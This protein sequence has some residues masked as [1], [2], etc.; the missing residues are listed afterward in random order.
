[1]PANR[2]T[3][4]A[5]T[6]ATLANMAPGM[7]LF[8][9]ITAIV[10]ATGSRAPL[11]FALAAVAM[12]AV[13]NT[14]AEFS[15]VLPSAGSFVTFISHGF[16]ASRR[17]G[18]ML[19]GVAFYLL[20]ISFPI[21]QAAV[22]TFLGW[23]IVG[24]C[25]WTMPFAWL[26]ASAFFMVAVTPV[27]F[28]GVALSSRIA[29][30]LFLVDACGLLLLSVCAL[31]VARQ[32]LDLPFH[33]WGGSARGLGGLPGLPFVLAM[34]S[35]IGWENAGPLAEETVN[36]RRTI[37]RTVL[38]SVCSVG[39]IYVV[40]SWALVSGFAGWWGDAAGMA[41]LGHGAVESPFVTLARRTLPAGAWII[42]LVGCTSALGC[43][44]AEVTSQA[45][46]LFHGA[47]GPVARPRR[48]P[49]RSHR[50]AVRRHRGVR[51][52]DRPVLRG[53]HA[54]AREQSSPPLHRGGWPRHGTDL[55][56]LSA[57]DPG[58]TRLHAARAA[59]AVRPVQASRR[60]DPRRGAALLRDVYL[61]TA[62]S[63][64][65]GQYVLARDGYPARLQQH[66]DGHRVGA[67]SD[68]IRSHRSGA[69][70]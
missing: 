24:M 27:L 55:A 39:A 30:T 1:M 60:P 47:R 7:T 2:L 17:T 63:T 36:P 20:L 38:I 58:L 26:A 28:R 42:G 33:D 32:H 67:S 64:G 10:S 52:I 41:M 49:K 48:A 57:R 13:G 25:G 6:A 50:D 62:R 8:L 5:T 19:G 34:F 11:A 3:L 23:W 44:V 29:L 18:T 54:V 51:R 9:S 16:G 21:T 43:F 59:R 12:L 45:R 31:L 40:A 70:G 37:A 69:S 53:N 68:G 15:R 56:H 22:V 66:R 4:V 46:I 65:A 35:Y 14:M 61:R